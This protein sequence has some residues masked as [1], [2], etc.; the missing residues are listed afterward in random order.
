[1]MITIT[2]DYFWQ[3]AQRLTPGSQCWL[4]DKLY[5]RIEHR[6][7]EEP[8]P[9]YTMEELNVR[10]ERLRVNIRAG[11]VH[12]TEEVRQILESKYQWLCE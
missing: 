1:M 6:E 8:L 7:E 11:R 9:P 12:T 2:A 3:L 5:E 10:I 4:V